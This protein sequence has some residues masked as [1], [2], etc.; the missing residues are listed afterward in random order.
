MPTPIFIHPPGDCRP[1]L[2]WREVCGHEVLRQPGETDQQLHDRAL[3]EADERY[4]SEGPIF[5]AITETQTE[6]VTP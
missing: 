1:V 2:G 5:R 3:R 6:E 4:G